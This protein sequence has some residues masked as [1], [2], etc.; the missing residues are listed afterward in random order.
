MCFVS[1]FFLEMTTVSNNVFIIDIFAPYWEKKE[2]KKKVVVR[3]GTCSG[4][5]LEP[6]VETA[7]VV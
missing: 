5:L 1:P 2:K 4:Q 6:A 3:A 7:L